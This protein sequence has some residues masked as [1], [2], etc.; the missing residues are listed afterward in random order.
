MMSRTALI[1]CVA[2]AL[3]LTGFVMAGRVVYTLNHQA[4]HDSAQDKAWQQ[5][6][7]AAQGQAPGSSPAPAESPSGTSVEIPSGLY[8]KMTLAKLG[9]DAVAVN[10]DWDSLKTS[11]TVHYK[12]S[13]APGQKGNMLI[14]FHREPKW[15]DINLQAG[16]MVRIDALDRKTY[17]YKVDFVKIVSAKD[18]SDLKATAGTDLTLITCDPPWQDYNR[19]VVR[20][21]LVPSV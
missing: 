15:L 2:V 6:M 12:T 13:P 21:H 5:F 7:G 4:S 8:L 1:R 20:A 18:V 19:M 10:G 14:A 11:S 9:R 3:I 16:D 17:M